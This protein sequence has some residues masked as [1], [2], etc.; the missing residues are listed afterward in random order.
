MNR[1]K[2]RRS[3][4]AVGM[5]G[6]KGKSLTLALIIE[7]FSTFVKVLANRTNAA[8]GVDM[9]HEAFREILSCSK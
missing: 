3:S 4:C 5:A 2:K 1:V 9:I 7:R 6:R 8:R